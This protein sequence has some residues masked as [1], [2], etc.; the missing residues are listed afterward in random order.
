MGTRRYRGKII[1]IEAFK[2]MIFAPLL[3]SNL[4]SREA[5]LKDQGWHQS[6]YGSVEQWTVKELIEIINRPHSHK[7]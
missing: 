7:T 4:E 5:Q 2:A 3:H 6:Q 1:I